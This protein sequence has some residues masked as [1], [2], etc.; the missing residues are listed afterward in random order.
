VK[1]SK[2]ILQARRDLEAATVLA[3]GGFHEWACFVSPQAAEKAEKAYFVALG[4]EPPFRRGK[5][6]HDLVSL[7]SGWPDSVKVAEPA[8]RLAEA[9]ARL[10][11]HAENTRYPHAKSDS[12]EFIS[13]SEGYGRNDSQQAIDD[14]RAVVE[15]CT[16][17][18]DEGQRFA[19]SLG[20][21]LRKS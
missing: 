5:E 4:M 2:W 14:A 1:Y 3:A 6:G 16:K 7:S 15:V 11:Q 12:E 17:L 13:P 21:V 18:A 10:N 20:E 19:S 9:Q 8:P